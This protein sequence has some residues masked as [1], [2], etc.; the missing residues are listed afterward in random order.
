MFDVNGHKK[1][2]AILQQAVSYLPPTLYSTVAGSQ[3][4]CLYTHDVHVMH[5]LTCEGWLEAVHLDF[6]LASF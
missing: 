6:A 4:S 5:F 2:A 1:T 3:Y